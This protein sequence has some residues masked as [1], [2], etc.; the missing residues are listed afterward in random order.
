MMDQGAPAELISGLLGFPRG[1]KLQV[2]L[3]F[4]DLLMLLSV[5]EQQ[6]YRYIHAGI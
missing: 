1:T 4:L 6:T 5:W 3:G 2:L